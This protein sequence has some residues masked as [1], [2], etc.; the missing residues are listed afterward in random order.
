MRDQLNVCINQ[1]N[2]VIC[3][4]D[5]DQLIF[6]VLIKIKLFQDQKSSLESHKADEEVAPILATEA[7]RVEVER[8]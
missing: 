4:F 7:L 2:L 5:G 1:S 3:V 8:I 6:N